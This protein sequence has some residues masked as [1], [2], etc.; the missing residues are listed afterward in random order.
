[1]TIYGKMSLSMG[2]CEYQHKTHCQSKGVIFGEVRGFQ[3]N[4][5][6]WCIST[7]GYDV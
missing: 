1:M 2:R 7:E 4:V 5:L 3:S 6:K